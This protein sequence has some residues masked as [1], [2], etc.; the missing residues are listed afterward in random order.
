[1]CEIVRCKRCNHV[2]KS[3][4]SIKRGYGR[5]CYR[6]VQLQEANKPE[7]KLETNQEIAFLKCEIKTLKMMIRNIQVKGAIN[8]IERIKRNR[9]EQKTD[10]NESNYGKVMIEMKD[11][12][13]KMKNGYK[14]LKSVN[15]IEMSIEPPIQVLA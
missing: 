15:S 7:V 5:V 10:G 6:I 4:E 13:S 1:M 2:L 3:T 12:F 8:P 11:V 14:H 9:P